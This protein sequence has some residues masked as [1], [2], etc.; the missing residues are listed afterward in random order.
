MS[1]LSTDTGILDAVRFIDQ[2]ESSQRFIRLLIGMQI[3][4]WSMATCIK[5]LNCAAPRAIPP[6]TGS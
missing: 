2:D 3:S 5:P 6:V 1:K 4:H